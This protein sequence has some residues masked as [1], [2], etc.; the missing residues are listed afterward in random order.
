IPPDD[1]K[2]LFGKF[3]RSSNVMTKETTGSGLGLYITKNIINRHGGEISIESE[4]NRGTTVSFTL[5][6]D[7]S[8]VPQKEMIYGE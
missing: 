6:T 5:P 1:L 4:L 3:F 2:K 7:P 8:L